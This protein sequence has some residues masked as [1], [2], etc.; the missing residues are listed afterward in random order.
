LSEG[1]KTVVLHVISFFSPIIHV[2]P[3]LGEI[4]A[5][6]GWITGLQASVKTGSSIVVP[7]LFKSVHVWFC[8]P[9]SQSSNPEQDQFGEQFLLI[10]VEVK[11]GVGVGLRS[12]AVAADAAAAVG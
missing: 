2:S 1:E 3:P 9:L 6:E 12:E 7:H 5:M 8:Q 10:E 11:A 4:T